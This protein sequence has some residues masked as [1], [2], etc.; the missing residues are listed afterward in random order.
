MGPD[1]GHEAAAL[2]LSVSRATYFRRLAVAVERLAP[3][4]LQERGR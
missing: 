4:V 3:R 2:A 1:G